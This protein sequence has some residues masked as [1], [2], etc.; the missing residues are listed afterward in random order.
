MARGL[1]EGAVA[2]MLVLAGPGSPALAQSGSPID[3][4]RADRAPPLAPPPLR[5][6]PAAATRV[7][8]GDEAAAPIA[9][10]SF[11]GT[12][13]PLVV[14]EAVR[15]FVGRPATR[16][17]LQA[18]VDAM[19]E[20][21]GRSEVALFTIVVP[22]QDLSSGDVRILVA[23]GHLETVLLTGEV[24]GRRL[25]LVR[26]YAD[27]LVRQRPTRRATLE[28]YLSLIRDIPGLKVRTR[29]E[30]GEGPGGVRMIVA[31]DYSRPTVSLSFDN[32]T[33]RQV[34]DGQVQAIARGYGLLREGDMTE[35]T[36]AASVNF[37]DLI[38]AGVTHSTPLGSEGTR[39][40]LTGGLLETRPPASGIT[41]EAQAFG[42]TLSHPLIRGYR[43]NLT[44]SLAWDG[45]NSDNAAFGSLI[46]SERTRAVRAAAA[47]AQTGRR[48]AFSASV[49]ASRGLDMLGARVPAAIGKAGFAKA[50]GRAA[51]DQALGRRA[52][53]RL[54]ASGQ[55]TRD[56]LPVAERFQVGG[57]DY[58]RAFETGLI[59]ADRGYAASGELALRPL[60]AGRLAGSEV[61]GF[62][63]YAAVRLLP[64]PG[65]AGRNFDLASA[66]AGVRLAFTDKAMLELELA[67]TLDR[68]YPGYAS[69]WRV[70]LGWRISLRP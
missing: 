23:E 52:V 63:D 9:T 5:D 36:A 17:T 65:A 62:A 54:R 27:R 49:T 33:T 2:L 10:V 34:R 47:Y 48:R 32:R 64:R 28:R 38:Y 61:Y 44:L 59:S 68:P 37:R 29:L 57:A 1:R 8:A 67:R 7:E 21:Y 70:S 18:L 45:L 56:R 55:W 26:A 50:N 22:A 20:A 13:V 66:G 14:A 16:A 25:D 6:A 41:G 4:E 46:A 43:R 60:R 3:R 15:P 35:L 53:L 11:A 69:N 39:L 31:L 42:V 30:T 19:S 51:F 12:H 58:G 40:T 24:T